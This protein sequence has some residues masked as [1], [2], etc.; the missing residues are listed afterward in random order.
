MCNG[1][2]T[3]SRCWRFEGNQEVTIKVLD[4]KGIMKSNTSAITYNQN[5][6]FWWEF[7]PGTPGQTPYQTFEWWWVPV[8]GS[9]VYWDQWNG[10]KSIFHWVTQSGT[11]Y[12]RVKVNGVEQVL[13]RYVHYGPPTLSLDAT[14][15]T[16]LAGDTV[17]FEAKVRPDSTPA[18]EFRWVW[19]PEVPVIGLHGERSEQPALRSNAQVSDIQSPDSVPVTECAGL[20]TCAYVVT[21]NGQM[22]VRAL[23]AGKRDSAAKHIVLEQVVLTLVADKSSV[24]QGERVKFEAKASGRKVTV[25]SWTWTSAGGPSLT[26]PAC[27][28]KPECEV[29]IWE[30]GQMTV[31]ATIERNPADH[32]ASVTVAVTACNALTGDEADPLLASASVRKDFLQKLKESNAADPPESYTRIEKGGRVATDGQGNYRLVD[33]P[34]DSGTGASTYVPP[35]TWGPPPLG[36]TWTNWIWHTHP[37]SPGE[38]TFGGFAPNG[39]ECEDFMNDGKQICWAGIGASVADL[40][41]ARQSGFAVYHL[42]KDGRFVRHDYPARLDTGE[43]NRDIRRWKRDGRSACFKPAPCSTYAC[44]KDP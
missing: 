3:M 22:R 29:E 10:K 20:R 28:S 15:T 11:M 30:S 13:E 2:P 8:G 7:E 26:T 18:S 17:Q 23:V 9:P 43:D 27:T 38:R 24:K 33:V 5:V 41:W 37:H 21:S 36:W 14:P 25:K 42:D 44:R 35:S 16:I 1:D 12:V 40:T 19:Y 31:V 4:V 39:K 6:N 32:T 34:G